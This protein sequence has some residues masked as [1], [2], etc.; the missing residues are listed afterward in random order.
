MLTQAGKASVRFSALDPQWKHE[1]ITSLTAFWAL[2]G[3]ET[4][5]QR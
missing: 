5:V 1:L 4:P 3:I 2:I